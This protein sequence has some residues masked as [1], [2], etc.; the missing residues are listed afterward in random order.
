M[1]FEDYR[2]AFADV[3]GSSGYDPAALAAQAW[4]ESRFNPAAV[5]PAGARG[6]MQFMPATWEW[7]KTM[8]FIPANA[9]PFNPLHSI[10]AGAG[11]MKWLIEYFSTA[12]NPFHMALA[13]YNCGQG[14]VKKAIATAGGSTWA[15]VKP[16]LPAETQDYVEKITARIPIYQA[17]YGVA[18][19]VIPSA[20]I[21]ILAGFLASRS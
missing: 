5:S 17:V 7:A 14:R 16:Y 3:A 1:A 21:V 6:L 8:G 18:K 10:Q 2:Q 19:S 4:Q 20:L 11:Y 9:D 15:K 12:A 13:G